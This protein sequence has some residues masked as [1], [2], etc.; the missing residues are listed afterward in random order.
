MLEAIKDAVLAIGQFFA[1]VVD[2]VL[3]LISDIIYVIELCGQAISKVPDYISWI[4]AA[5]L[6]LLTSIFAIVVIYKILGREG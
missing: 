1:D 3:K 6:A 5:P 2:F 4:P